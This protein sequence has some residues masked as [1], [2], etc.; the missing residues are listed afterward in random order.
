MA[1]SETSIV[2]APTKTPAINEK[3]TGTPR[4]P[5][6]RKQNVITPRTTGALTGG[7]A[8]T[9]RPDHGNGNR[10]LRRL[11]MIEA[12]AAAVDQLLDG[13]Q[14]NQRAGKRDGRIE[15]RDR[16]HRRQPEAAKPA[17]IIEVAEIDEASRDHQADG[18]D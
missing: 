11:E 2:A 12:V 5:N 18:T 9:Q 7:L 13:E 8:S 1:A 16:G 10:L 3:G 4:Y 17:Q 6:N 14:K 15:R